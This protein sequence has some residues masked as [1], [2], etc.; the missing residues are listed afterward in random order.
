MFM[1]NFASSSYN[2]DL[3]VKHNDLRHSLSHSGCSAFKENEIK[4]SIWSIL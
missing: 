3:N 1:F 2:G 4:Y